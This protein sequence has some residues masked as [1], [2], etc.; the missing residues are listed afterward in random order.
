MG[1]VKRYQ[2]RHIVY[3]IAPGIVFLIV[4]Y[5]WGLLWAT[6]AVMV[7][8]GVFIFL[9][10]ALER[11]FPVFPIVTVLLVLMLGGATLV[12]KAGLTPVAILG[13]IAITR[14]TAP[15]YWQEP[16]MDA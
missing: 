9:G 12:F 7:A 6:A 8:T 1:F 10:L 14:L 15:K 4:N 2:N 16:E 11:R 5:I 13:Y 3:E